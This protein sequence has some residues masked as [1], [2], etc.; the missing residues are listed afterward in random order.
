MN[1][2]NIILFFVVALA[3]IGASFG[4]TKSSVPI[5]T[6]PKHIKLF[7]DATVYL[8]TGETDSGTYYF[9]IRNLERNAATTVLGTFGVKCQDSAGTDTMDVT[10]TVY[11]NYSATKAGVPEGV[12]TSL[13]T[14]SITSP[15]G[16]LTEGIGTVT[17]AEDPMFIWVHLTNDE[18]GAGTSVGEKAACTDAFWTVRAPTTQ[19]E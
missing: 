18:T 14:V 5:K 12:W 2:K 16:A 17:D 10:M 3:F 7:D 4:Q 9:D 11:G 15:T 8:D 6:P 1:I 19:R 13:G